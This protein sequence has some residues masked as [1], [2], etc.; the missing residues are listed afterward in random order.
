MAAPE[1]AG[2]RWLVTNTHRSGGSQHYIHTASF[3][4]AVL[5][6]KYFVLAIESRGW[7]PDLVITHVGYGN[8]LYV[9]DVFPSARKIGFFSGITTVLTRTSIFCS[10]GRLRGIKLFDCAPGM[11]TLIEWL[12]VMWASSLRNS[13]AISF[14]NT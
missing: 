10:P 4:Q 7:E 12:T 6:G 1:P 14:L 2:F 5:E 3:D 8:G 11:Q 9:R 13:S